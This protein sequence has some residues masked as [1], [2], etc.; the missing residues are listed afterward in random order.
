MVPR[1]P[2]LTAEVVMLARNSNLIKVN[3]LVYPGSGEL[4]RWGFPLFIA[5][6]PTRSLSHLPYRSVAAQSDSYHGG[7]PNKEYH[8]N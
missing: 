6:S 8:P 4:T 3:V 7:P 2:I 5:I 1:G